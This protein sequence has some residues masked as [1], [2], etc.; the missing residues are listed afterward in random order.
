M[1][2]EYKKRKMYKKEKMKKAYKMYN[3]KRETGHLKLF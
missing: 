1:K 2:K 3:R